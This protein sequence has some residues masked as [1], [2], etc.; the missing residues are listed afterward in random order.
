MYRT[1]LR[2]C[3]SCDEPM[4]KVPLKSMRFSDSTIDACD[5][6]GGVFLDFFD[7]EPFAVARDVVKQLEDFESAFRVGGKLLTCPDCGRPM[8]VHPYVDIGPDLAR[9]NQCMAVFAT[10][11]QIRALSRFTIHQDRPGFWSRLA[12][13]FG[14]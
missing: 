12:G 1:R 5:E 2:A 4:R 14:L 7:G 9:C 10:P 11:A 13:L 8:E 6:C 3:P